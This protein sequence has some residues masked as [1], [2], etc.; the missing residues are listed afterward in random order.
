MKNSILLLDEKTKNLIAA[1]EVIER[2]ASVV[3]EL[4]ENALDAGAR[5]IGVELESAGS[6]LIRVSDDGS[7]MG[8]QDA[9]LAFCRHATSKIRSA[10]DLAHIATLGFRGEA[11]PSIAAVSRFELETATREDPSGTLVV[12]EGGRTLEVS[13]TARAAGTTATVRNL[14]FNVPARRKFMKSDQTELRHI[15]RNMTQVAVAQIETAFRVSHEGRELINAPAAVTLSERVEALFGAKRTGKML[16][17][18]LE[19]GESA[20]GGLIQAPDA[21]GD[22][23]A[24][25][26][27]FINRRPFFSRALA[28]AVRQGY[29]STIPSSGQPSFFLFLTLDP[30]EVDVNVHPAKLEVRF[31]DE[32]YLF[33]LLH[34][35]VEQGLR[36]TGATPEFEG[37]SMSSGRLTRGG[38]AAAPGPGQLPRRVAESVRARGSG[39][40]QTSFLMPLTPAAS[41]P[42]A[43]STAPLKVVPEA[44]PEPEKAPAGTAV[45][46]PTVLPEIWQLHDRYIF[47][48]TKDGCM[49]IDQHAAHERILYEQILAGMTRGGMSR[50][51]LLFPFTLDLSPE[52][53]AAA[54][55]FAALLEQAGFELEDFGSNSVV[56]RST[57]ALEGLGHAEGYLREMLRDLVREGQGST[58]TRHQRLARSLACRAAIK[59]GR[60]MEGREMN[61]LV[62]RLFATELPYADVHGRNTMVHLSLEEVDRRFG[63]T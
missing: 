22:M 6:R 15:L 8:R 47:V 45:E 61:E 30:S 50:Q 18:L 27:M 41:G 55:D 60:R 58:G 63:R 56:I 11:L 62:D 7:G 36:A 28:Q 3:K 49:I 17:V 10:D 44:G 34:R 59:S 25:Q 38:V 2:P 43:Q 48:E 4:V 26:Y 12:I 21:V 1:G 57:P 23:R 32:G 51:R 16:P 33:S 20:I 19:R 52:E 42:K 29:Q 24:E 35:A 53:H 31:R 46:S 54:L 40:F 13:E 5:R 37:A 9:E 39:A 14:F